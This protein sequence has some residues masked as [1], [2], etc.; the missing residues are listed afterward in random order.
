MTFAKDTFSARAS[1]SCNSKRQSVTPCPGSGSFARCFPSFSP[2]CC[3]SSVGGGRSTVSRFLPEPLNPSPGPS[4]A[5]ASW[6]GVWGQNV[7]CVCVCARCFV[8][9]CL[10]SLD[11][12]CV[13]CFRLVAGSN[14]QCC[15]NVLGRPAFGVSVAHSYELASP[16]H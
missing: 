9:L 3:A 13:C 4:S 8:S 16:S 5:R 6:L 2:Y 12:F 11:G 14:S 1:K 10:A 15:H 7:V